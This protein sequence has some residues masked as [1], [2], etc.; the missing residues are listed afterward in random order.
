MIV[1]ALFLPQLIHIEHPSFLRIDF[2]N[3]N[4]PVNELF[5]RYQ[6]GKNTSPRLYATKGRALQV[7]RWCGA[8]TRA[9]GAVPASRCGR[10]A[11]QSGARITA[12]RGAHLPVGRQ[13]FAG[14][15]SSPVEAGH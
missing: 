11:A 13:A 9:T 12:P 1:F 6:C 10:Q 7:V 3:E 2:S 15:P 8:V 5:H 14:V 4:Q